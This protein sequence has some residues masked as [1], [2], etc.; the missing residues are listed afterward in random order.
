MLCFG[1]HGDIYHFSVL[2]CVVKTLMAPAP[3]SQLLVQ[4]LEIYISVP[5]LPLLVSEVVPNPLEDALALLMSLT[6]SV[7]DLK[8]KGRARLTLR[9]LLERMPVVGGTRIA[10]IRPPDFEYNLNLGCDEG[11]WGVSAWGSA[12][13]VGLS[14]SCRHGNRIFWDCARLALVGAARCMGTSQSPRPSRLTSADLL[15]VISAPHPSETGLCWRRS[16]P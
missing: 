10:L 3:S 9:P 7:T 1:G 2:A 5:K 8:L 12:S 13:G 14:V 11:W 15:A 4:A 16:S 6:V